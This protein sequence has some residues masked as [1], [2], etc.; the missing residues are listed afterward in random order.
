MKPKNAAIPPVSTICLTPWPRL[1]VAAC[2]LGA[3]SISQIASADSYTYDADTATALVAQDGSGLGWNTPDTNTNWLLN[4]VGSNVAWPNLITDTAVFGAA[5]AGSGGAVVVGTVNV[6][7]ITFAQQTTPGYTLSTGSITL[8]TG[9]TTTSTVASTISAKISGTAG[10]AFTGVLNANNGVTLSGANDYTGITTLATGGRITANG[11]TALGSTAGATTSVLGGNHTVVS[12]QTTVA[13][14]NS[15]AEAFLISGIGPGTGSSTGGALRLTNGTTLSSFVQLGAS[16]LI[17]GN[18]GTTTISGNVDLAGFTLS[19][20]NGANANTLVLSGVVTNVGPAGGLTVNDGSGGANV[21]NLSN[22]AN[23][24]LGAT[25]VNGGGTLGLGGDAVLGGSTLVPNGGTIRSTNAT[26]RSIAN[27]IGTFTGNAV[28]GPTP[29]TPTPT[30]IG[31]LN[32]TSTAT[33]SLGTS[34]RTVTT[35]VDTTLAATLSNTGGLTK[36][37]AATLFLTNTASIRTGVTTI[38]AGILNVASLANGGTGNF[39]SIGASANTAG[40]L[41]L[42]GG[43]LQ[44]TGSSPQSTDRLFTVNASAAVP[45]T[46]SAIDASGSAPGASLVFTNAGAIGQGDLTRVV[47][48]PALTTTVTGLTSTANLKVGA[49]VTG[50]NIAANTTIAS[51]TDA[52]T[53]VLSPATTNAASAA[54]ITLTFTSVDR[55]LTLTGNNTDANSIAGILSDRTVATFP[56]GVLSLA[57]T[58][59]GTW[60]LSGANT[61]TGTTTVTAGTLL[62]TNTTGSATGTGTV[63]VATTGTLGGNGSIAGATTIS[64]GGFIAPGLSAGTLTLGGNTVIAGTYACQLDGAANGDKIAVTGNLDLTG[65]TLAVSTLGGG[66]SGDYVIAT[67]TGTLTGTFA[68]SPAL[69]SGYSVSYATAGQ[70]KLEFSAATDFDTWLDSFA[71]PITG[72]DRLPTGDPDGDGLKNQ[73][74]YAFGLVPNSGSSV[75]PIAVPLNKTTGKFS[76]TRRT[77]GQPPA[78]AYTVETSTNLT[79]WTVDTSATQDITGTVGQVQTVEVT[80]SAALL[81]ETKLFVRVLAQ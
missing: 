13:V 33:T 76:Y 12:S 7:L 4:N 65:S 67:Y 9:I 61:H 75:N 21:I 34:T 79:G 50:T 70:V 46:S 35:N 28:F 78:L 32:F 55:A 18:F 10:L 39:S 38:N 23:T 74:E 45:S 47:T 68:A 6:G 1:L 5:P 64:A 63:T 72:A 40:S 69:P 71:P 56:S 27:T 53:I 62:A 22:P 60:A 48:L 17:T 44:F 73:Q 51:I 43:T 19:N 8:G 29:A 59:T 20:G 2:S 80:L 36:A 3:L 66:A 54:N 14:Q 57:K 49:R 77:L 81:T 24:Y 31:T 26:A 11:A 30:Q 52:T 25:T 42:G 58:G 41:V 37:G 16:S 15:T